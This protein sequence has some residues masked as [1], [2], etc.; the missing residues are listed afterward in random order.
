LGNPDPNR[1]APPRIVLF[2][3]EEA[4]AGALKR[5][6]SEQRPKIY[7]TTGHGERDIYAS[8]SSGGNE[9]SGLGALQTALVTDG[10]STERYESLGHAIPSDCNVLAIIDPVQAFSEAEFASI[11]AYVQRGGRL[12]LTG[13]HRYSTGPGSTRELAAQYGV[14][15]GQGYVCEPMALPSGYVFGQS[16]C[17]NVFVVAEGLSIQHPIS[18]PLK[19]FDRTVWSPMTRPLSR[20][21]AVADIL[22][23]ELAQS[24]GR[25]WVDLPKG[26]EYDWKPDPTD[27]PTDRKFTVACAVELTPGGESKKNEELLRGRVV[28]LGSPEFLSTAAMEANRDFALNAFNWLAAREYRMSVATQSQERNM[29][30]VRQSDNLLKLRSLVLFGL[31]GLCALLGL[32]TWSLRRR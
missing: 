4:L 7:F 26:K 28:V 24:S 13:S 8:G 18:A 22:I 9:T 30:D 19:R 1:Y 3:G 16:G 5:V 21:A 31:P 27:E 20:K 17:A 6:S 15:L 10:F 2:R 11:E 12:L 14:E 25:A 32:I 29:I 23:T